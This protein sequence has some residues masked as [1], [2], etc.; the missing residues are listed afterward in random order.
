MTALP[1]YNR[2]IQDHDGNVVPNATVEVRREVA[3]QPLAQLYSDR[4]GTVTIGNPITAD[5]NGFV[6][7]HVVEGE[8]QVRVT[9]G[10]EET[11]LRYEQVG[12]P[13]LQVALGYE[14]DVTTG[15]YTV[16]ATDTFIVIK[17]SGPTLTTIT[18]PP[19]AD[20]NGVPLKWSDWSTSVVSDHEIRF[21]PDGSETVMKLSTYSAW[22]NAAGLSTGWL[23]PSD[24][25]T[26]WLV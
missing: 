11:T 1:R 9:A 8:Y 18:L 23:Y 13:A 26:G 20:R 12:Q 17:R 15:T 6:F 21:V 3:G 24:D 4:D 10:V 22:S 2:T 5:A 25:L 7:F 16:A 14:V 19:V